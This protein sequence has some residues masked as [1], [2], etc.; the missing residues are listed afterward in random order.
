VVK[1]SESTYRMRRQGLS[2]SDRELV[3]AT[4]MLVYSMGVAATAVVIFL[5]IVRGL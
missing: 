2:E 1:R 3:A 5:L 4:F